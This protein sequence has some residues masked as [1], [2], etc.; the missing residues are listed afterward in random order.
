MSNIIRD[1]SPGV[2]RKWEFTGF[3]QPAVATATQSEVLS[4][5]TSEAVQQFAVPEPE[6]APTEVI[7]NRKC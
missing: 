3:G 2:F 4:P 1:P 7:L 5:I 6:P